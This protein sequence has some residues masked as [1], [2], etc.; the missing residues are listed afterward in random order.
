MVLRFAA[1]AFAAAGLGIGAGGVHAKKTAD[2]G[3]TMMSGVTHA[4]AEISDGLS[5]GRR[6]VSSVLTKAIS[7]KAD[8]DEAMWPLGTDMVLGMGKSNGA[9]EKRKLASSISVS[10]RSQLRGGNADAAVSNGKQFGTLSKAQIA[11]MDPGLGVSPADRDL[12]DNVL[13]RGHLATLEMA[14]FDSHT[15]SLTGEAYAEAAGFGTAGSAKRAATFAATARSQ[16]EIDGLAEY[17]ERERMA[18][19]QTRGLQAA[20]ASTYLNQGHLDYRD[21]VAK[22]TKERCADRAVYEAIFSQEAVKDRRWLLIFKHSGDNAIARAE[23]GA[24]DQD[25]LFSNLMADYKVTGGIHPDNEGGFQPW[26]LPYGAQWGRFLT[27]VLQLIITFV[28]YFSCFYFCL[29]CVACRCGKKERQ[30]HHMNIFRTFQFALYCAAVVATFF[31]AFPQ[32]GIGEFFLL[33]SSPF[34]ISSNTIQKKKCKTFLLHTSLI[35][36][37]YK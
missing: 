29:C 7:A 28:V 9:G 30:H 21:L 33:S 11:R 32:L 17:Q 3:T 1:A 10:G 34:V 26:L 16:H 15:R 31:I 13:N 24:T 22:K 6:L 19:Y 5:Q 36:I 2:A 25:Q 23:K 18:G 37:Q 35:L 20:T 4:T 14:K 8:I 27:S 12:K